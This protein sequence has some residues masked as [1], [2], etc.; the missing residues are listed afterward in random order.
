MVVVTL[1]YRLGPFG[2]LSHTALDAVRGAI[3]SGNDGLRDQQLALRWV[4]DNIAAFGGDPGKVTLAG[5]SAGSM[6]ACLQLVSP[7]SRTLA[8]Q[9]VLESASCLGGL[10][11]LEKAASDTLGKT[12]TDELCAGQADLVACLRAKTPEELSGWHKDNGLF[13]AGFNPLVNPADPFL[14]KKP[15]ALIAA[16]DYNKGPII[17]GTNKNEWGLFELI[18]NKADVTSLAALTA[19]IDA[20]FPANAAAVKAQYLP[21]TDAE[22]SRAFLRL[23]TDVAFRC[24]TRALARLTSSQG[25]KVYLYS[26]EALPAYHAF[27]IPYVFGNPNATLLTPVLDP[28]TL[29]AV[30]GRWVQFTLTG[31]PNGKVEPSWPAYVTADDAHIALSEIT[32]TGSGLA[33]ADCDFWATQVA[34]QTGQ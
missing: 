33:K 34:A 8:K 30:Q 26:Y 24:P 4:Q 27:E 19:A 7:E 28:R 10:P 21:A 16:G 5:E 25:S 1:N 12:L 18:D 29:A 14:P 17:M 15:A 11:L 6:S 3:P 32:A 23:M 20:Q 31:D 9:F 22:V 13:G 2:F